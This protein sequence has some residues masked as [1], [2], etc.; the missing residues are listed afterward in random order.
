MPYDETDDPDAMHDMAECFVEEYVRLGFSTERIL[1]MFRDGQFA[2]PAMAYGR[3][4]AEVIEGIVAEQIAIRGPRASRRSVDRSPSG[5]I[6]L[7]ILD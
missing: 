6:E 7:P 1:E 5:A 3:L 2:G 4:G